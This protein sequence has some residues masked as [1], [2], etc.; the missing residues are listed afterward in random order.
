MGTEFFVSLD[1]PALLL[2]QVLMPPQGLTFRV[3]ICHNH[4]ASG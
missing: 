1:F 4:M 2:V 3:L